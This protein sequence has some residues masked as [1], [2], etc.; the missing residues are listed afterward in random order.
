METI[1][2]CAICGDHAQYTC[3]TC[4]RLVC[5]NHYYVQARMCSQCIPATERRKAEHN[6]GPP[7]LFG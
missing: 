3:N 4:G 2:L 1:G 7:P 6:K 5:E